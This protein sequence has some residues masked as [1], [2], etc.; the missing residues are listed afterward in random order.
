MSPS[1]EEALY[2]F[3]ENV[4]EPFTL[5]NIT[6]YVR[7]LTARKTPRL[8]A[9]I[10]ALIE[11]RSLAFKQGMNRWISRRGCFEPLRFVIN[12]T[13]LELVNGIL[14]PGHR[15][16]PFANP[17]L[18]P[19]SYVF[20]W[21]GTALPATT[22]EGPPEEFYPYY[23][24][25]GEE[26]APQY[27][28]R[29]NP[30]NETAFNSDPYEDPPEVSIHTV[31]MRN[32]YRETSFVPGD[33]FAVKTLDWK[34]GIFELERIGGDEW[35][36]EELDAWVNA[37]ETGFEESFKRLGPGFST[38][39]QIAFAYW[40]GGKRMR[41]L[42]AY[43]LEDFLYE[44][45]SRIEITGYGIETR[46]WYAG[47][48]IPDRKNLE[49][50]QTAVTD[51]TFIEDILDH[52]G[53]PISEFV[54]Q[55][56]VR[57]ALYRRDPDIAQLVLRIVP[58]AV[59]MTEQD[60]L[61][62]AEYAAGVYQEFSETYTVFRDK[63]MGPLR[64]RVCELHT[65]VIELAARLRNGGVELTWLPRHT[66]VV[67]SQIQ[68]HS[69]SL[70]EDLD[71]DDAPPAEEL[72]FMEN[73]LDSMIETFDDLKEQ[74]EDAAASFRQNNISMVRN[75]GKAGRP[76]VRWRMVQLGLGGTDI[77]RRLVL[78]ENETLQELQGIIKSLFGWD[79]SAPRRFISGGQELGLKTALAELG[80][81]GE[82]QY[83]HG[84]QWVVKII[85]LS[86]YDPGENERIRCVAGAG[87]APPAFIDG[88]LR[89]RKFISSFERGDAAERRM[90]LDKL[91][92]HFHPDEFDVEA[93]NRLLD[94]L[95]AAKKPKLW[96]L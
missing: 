6:S 72:G 37:A 58:Q 89:Y 23:T 88:P 94:S 80:S 36:E 95:L 63:G 90:V 19:Q 85:F 28:S 70:L 11:K 96:L 9:E 50:P 68:G 15:C 73:S 52:Y 18:M 32:L 47:K 35:S 86:V 83:E 78:P 91:G 51:R 60:L 54:T 61:C 8:G 24:I 1:Q 45:T 64:Q 31:D 55:S 40:Y 3:L 29:D 65:A 13:R 92:A 41:D 81:R 76:G 27:V 7:M 5:D 87:E 21:R 33:R 75:T 17:V 62:L 12:P 26:Y 30:E 57:D 56:Y 79:D 82:V 67:L 4:T 43:S 53:I 14:I 49:G 59:G 46:F 34:A 48:E 77:W 44:K 42:P 69:A 71:I 66:F 25:F 22:T 10:T 84:P 16:I 74:I 20:Y 38:D 93:C 2:E 39:E